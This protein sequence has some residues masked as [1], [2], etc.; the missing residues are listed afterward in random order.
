MLWQNPES[1]SNTK[2]SDIYALILRQVLMSTRS[3]ERCRRSVD[4]VALICNDSDG[5]NRGPSQEN[6]T[7]RRALTLPVG[8]ERQSSE[9]TSN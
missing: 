7:A 6:G 5:D 2:P 3:H 9:G 8:T 1:T 4:A